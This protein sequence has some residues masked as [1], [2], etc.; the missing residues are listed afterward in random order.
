MMRLQT[1]QL[2]WNTLSTR[3]RYGAY[4]AGGAIGL[5]VLWWVLLA[6][7]LHTL[8]SAPTEQGRL[9]AQLQH[10]QRLQA[11]AQVL[12]TQPR[13]S[14]DDALRAL[15]QSVKQRLGS[16]AQLNVSGTQATL[17]LKGVAAD[18]LAQWLAQARINAHA[19]LREARLQRNT[20]A[21]PAAW[22]GTLVLGLPDN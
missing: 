20:A 15:D 1:L 4:L 8:A 9:D 10:M 3:E 5:A 22:D 7:A 12:K 2:R 18:A 11:Q 16:A 17:T 6:P 21:T 13:T 14:R 19:T